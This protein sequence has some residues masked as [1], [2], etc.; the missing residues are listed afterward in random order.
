MRLGLGIYS[1]VGV[2]VLR[3]KPENRLGNAFEFKTI[4]SGGF[5]GFAAS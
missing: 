3:T 1:A 5:I 4:A 2:T